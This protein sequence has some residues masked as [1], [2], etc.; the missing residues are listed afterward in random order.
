MR[1]SNNYVHD[2]DEMGM[3]VNGTT[4]YYVITTN[5]IKSN[6]QHGIFFDQVTKS[7]IS[8]NSLQ[9]NGSNSAYD[10]IH[11]T[12]NS[13]NNIIVANVVTASG[14]YGVEINSGGGAP[15]KSTVVAN[16]LSGNGAG[17]LLDN[18]TNTIN[19]NNQT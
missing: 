12:D 16:N 8:G 17:A 6:N 3:R 18:G 13:D 4:Q 19:A 7:S 11:L 1:I 9:D 5:V 2:N 10:G 14:G 15:D